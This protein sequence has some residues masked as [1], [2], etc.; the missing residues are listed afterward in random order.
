MPRNDE[1]EALLQAQYDWEAAWP[2]EKAA[3]QEIFDRL[4]K[5]HVRKYNATAAARNKP[6]IFEAQLREALSERYYQFKK[7]VD[8]EMR[9]KINRLK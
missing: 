9:K 1:L 7:S 3:Y 4:V 5:H 6:E 2:Q 8:V